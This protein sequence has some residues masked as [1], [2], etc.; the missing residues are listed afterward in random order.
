LTSRA[1]CCLPHTEGRIVFELYD[2]IV[3]KTAENFRALCTGEKGMGQM[4]KPLHYKDSGFHRIIPGFM[5]QVGRRSTYFAFCVEKKKGDKKPPH[6][7]LL[8]WHVDVGGR[9][10]TLLTT[11]AL[12]ASPSTARSL[13]MKTFR[14]RRQDQSAV[15][16]PTFSQTGQTHKALPAVDGQRWP[17]PQ[18]LAIF[19]HGGSNVMA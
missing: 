1:H 5:C 4:G 8:T 18:R 13:P 2:D 9:A 14:F 17:G 3:P 6:H 19:Y 16:Q 7:H 15:T 10:V 12:A 11:T